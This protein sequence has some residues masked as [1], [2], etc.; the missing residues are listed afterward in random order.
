MALTTVDG[1]MLSATNAQYTGFKNRLINGSMLIWQRGTTTVN[2]QA[3]NA[4]FYTADRWACNRASNVTGITVSQSTDVPT[5][6]K[7]S[8]KLQRTAANTALDALYLFNSNESI[9]TLDLAGQTVTIS[10]WAKAGANYSGGALTIILSTGT[11]TDQPV[12][13]FTN[14][15]ATIATTQA[16]TTT[17]TRYSFTGTLPSNATEVGSYYYWTPTGTAGADDAVY[18][19][20]FQLEKGSTATAFD[21]RPYGTEL[22]LCQRYFYQSTYYAS[23]SFTSTQADF[24]VYGPSSPAN[25]WLWA[26]QRLPVQMRAAPTITTSDQAGTTGKLSLFTTAGGTS[27][28]GTTPYTIY[29]TVNSYNVSVY[30]E[31]KYGFFGAIKADSEL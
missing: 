18:F 9:N 10:F 7:Y 15:A 20:G 11:G 3:G 24:L 30:Y 2:P 28:N 12:Y 19:T 29:T 31:A 21:Y 6:F 22:Q 27:T 8:L 14:A 13:A 26:C 4:N 1:G 25:N 23:I 5:G 17:W 16:I